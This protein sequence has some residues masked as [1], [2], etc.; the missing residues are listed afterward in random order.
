LLPGMAVG[1]LFGS[2]NVAADI[3]LKHE[4]KRFQLET[5]P[6][7]G[8]GSPFLKGRHNKSPLTEGGYIKSKFD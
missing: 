2:E 7:P 1:A 6:P 5:L 3:E 4:E 8:G